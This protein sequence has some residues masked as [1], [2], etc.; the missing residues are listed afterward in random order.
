[1]CINI[2]IISSRILCCCFN[3]CIASLISPL[4]GLVGGPVSAQGPVGQ[5]GDGVT[6]GPRSLVLTG[7]QTI[8]DTQ[9]AESVERG[10]AFC[11]WGPA[12]LR[13]P[14]G[15]FPP[16]P[17]HC[18]CWQLGGSHHLRDCRCQ[19]LQPALHAS[20]LP[21]PRARLA[22]PSWG[23]GLTEPGARTPSLPCSA[24]S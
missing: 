7:H 20:L 12:S 5:G 1:M 17:S 22:G 15:L 2:F 9:V 8:R 3:P 23:A 24:E 11:S 16:R 13:R 14:H 19:T 18:S 4:P 6:V 10:W 21:S